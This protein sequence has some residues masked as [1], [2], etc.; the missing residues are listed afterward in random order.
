MSLWGHDMWRFGHRSKHVKSLAAELEQTRE[1]ATELRIQRNLLRQQMKEAKASEHSVI[2]ELHRLRELAFG[3]PRREPPDADPSYVFIVSCGRTGSTLVQGVLNAIPGVLIRGENGGVLTD[4]FR[5]HTTAGH[6]RQRLIRDD[7]LMRAT[8]AWFGIDGYP[9]DLA[10][11][12]IRQLV[13]DLLLRPGPG[14][15]V[16][17]CKEIRWDGVD[18][19]GYF[20]FL[21]EVFPGARF[22]MSS[23]RLEDVVSSGWWSRRANAID[24]LTALDAT[25]RTAIA[26]LGTAGF[27]LRYEDFVDNPDGLRPVFDWL[28]LEFRRAAIEAAMTRRY[29]YEPRVAEE[30][31]GDWAAASQ[32]EPG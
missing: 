28:G 24:E 7:K 22:I 6:H 14:T 17:G 13:T 27:E 9:E 29:S 11:R 18:V 12:E 25:L 23:R 15:D 31:S 1:R 8:N 3:D 5:F 21:R 10:R 30:T 19:A 16:I 20:G 26:E 2:A 4:L 32:P